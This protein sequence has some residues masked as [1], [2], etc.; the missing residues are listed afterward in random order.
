VVEKCAKDEPL[1]WTIM[2]LIITPQLNFFTPF[3]QPKIVLSNLTIVVVVY[4]VLAQ[5]FST[6]HHPVVSQC[7]VVSQQTIVVHPHVTSY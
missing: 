4:L 1:K 6:A 5:Y 3:V 7:L 2:R